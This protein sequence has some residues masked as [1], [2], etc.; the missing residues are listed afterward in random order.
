M[1]H[2]LSSTLL[3]LA[4]VQANAWVVDSTRNSVD[5]CIGY[6]ELSYQHPSLEKADSLYDVERFTEA[7]LL[8]QSAA[9]KFERQQDWEGLLKARNRVADCYRFTTTLKDSAYSILKGN[10]VIIEEHFNNDPYEIAEVHFILGICYDWGNQKEKALEEF[11]KSVAIRNELY[12]EKHVDVV[13]GYKFIG[14]MFAWDKRNLNA[15]E[16]LTKAADIAATLECKNSS[17]IGETYYSLASVARGLRD[18]EKAG[19]YGLKSLSLFENDP[20]SRSR[21]YNLIANINEHK[22]Q[23]EQSIRYNTL[24]INLLQKQQP[25][26]Y[27]QQQNLANY[28]HSLANVNM[29]TLRYDSAHLYYQQSLQIYNKLQNQN[30]VLLLYQNIGVNYYLLGRHDSANYYLSKAVRLG[31]QINGEKHFATSASLLE[32]GSYYQQVGQLDS[33]LHY[34]QQAIVAATGP[35]YHN[36]QPDTN[37]ARE[38]FTFD[39]NGSLLNALYLKGSVLRKIYLQDQDQGVLEL[40]LETLLLALELMD[41]NQELYQLEGSTLFM[42]EEN[43]S[44][45]EG[46]LSVCYNLYQLTE[47]QE[48]LETAFFIIEK[49]KA[50]LLFDT[51]YDLQQSR[52]VGIPDSLIQAENVIKSRLASFSRDLENKEQLDS[53]NSR[54]IRELEDKVFQATVELENFKHSLE[55]AYPAYASAIKNEPLDLNSLRDRIIKENRI[56]VNYFWGDSALYTL[57]LQDNQIGFFRQPIDTL[58]QLVEKYQRHLVD[59]PQFTNQAARF[60]EFHETAYALF[61]VLFKG[62]DPDKRSLIIAADGPLRFIPFEGLVVE[63]PA[64]DI[65]DYHQLN[66]VVNHYPTSYVYSANMWAMQSQRTPGKSQALG[67][68]HSAPDMESSLNADNELPGTARE[69]EILKGQLQGSFFS[70]LEATKQ[71]F[72]DHARD[73]DIIHLSIHGISD[74]VSRLNN[75]LLFRNPHDQTQTDP[76][77]TYELYN[78]QLNSRLAVLSACES[79]TGRNYQGEGVY[80]M[81]RAF[82]YA[83]CPTTVMSLWRIS[84]KTTPEILEQFYRQINKGMDIDQALHHAKL[85]YL[86]NH[87]GS[88]AHPS[89][90]A[91]MVVHGNTDPVMKKSRTVLTLSIVVALIVLTIVFIKGRSKK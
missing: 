12:D 43:Y 81:S 45:F 24:A 62:I 58:E 33:A 77:Y 52:M 54:E 38:S 59:G 31:K 10:L 22:N 65:T 26:D 35:D 87:R 41:V 76:L 32:Q 90:W 46:A 48:Y 25:L 47:S 5:P 83:G 89:Y 1:Y 9:E 82:S 30:E 13:R 53:A 6:W 85:D 51:F 3:L 79:G 91:A 44:V 21:S 78:L 8:Y 49:S 19:I 88:A 34:Y 17:L 29:Q 67:F 40:S 20:F 84:D 27:S 66:Y 86:E 71:N 60:R 18:L 72:I 50:R 70:G 42:A 23:F 11:N 39:D 61:S 14:D 4:M 68:S 2:L 57:V 7:L 74:S 16:Y 64:S 73:Y 63:D 28:L 36:Y 37:P 15:V 56:L 75:R 55:S 80:S 69:I